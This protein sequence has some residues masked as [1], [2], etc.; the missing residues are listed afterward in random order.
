MSHDHRFR[1][2]KARA[3]ADLIERQYVKPSGDDEIDIAV[4]EI[5]KFAVAE[6]RKRAL[7]LESNLKV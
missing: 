6:L 3:I 2:H 4:E 1:A 5:R 7:A